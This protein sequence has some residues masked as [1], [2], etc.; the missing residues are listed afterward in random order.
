ME[1]QISKI[2]IKVLRVCCMNSSGLVDHA[3]Q[4]HRDLIYH[5]LSDSFLQDHHDLLAATHREGRD[6]DLATFSDGI[7]DHVYQIDLG[8]FARGL[9]AVGPTV[10]GLSHKSFQS[11]KIAYGR[12]EE[13]GSLELVVAGKG[14]IVK[15][16][17]NMEVSNGGAQDMPGIVHGQF[18][19]GSD[20]SHIAIVE[21]DGM[22]ESLANHAGVVWQPLSLAAGHFQIIQLQENKQIP[23]RRSAVDRTFVAVFVKH[24]N[25]T[26]MVQVSMRQDHGINLVKRIDLRYIEKRRGRVV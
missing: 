18:G 17:S 26:G 1:Y 3:I 6:D 20:V 5:F 2:I 24:G 13:P 11:R 14:H 16:V 4:A 7:L 25:E 22:L 19:V 21:G 23:G 8:F 15:A 12:I 10:S 9:N